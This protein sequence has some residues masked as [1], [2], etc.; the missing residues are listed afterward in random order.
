MDWM[1]AF[2][3]VRVITQFGIPVTAVGNNMLISREAY[4]STGGYEKIPFS[5]T[6]DFELFRQTLKQGWKYKNL[7]Q[8][9]VLALTVPLKTINHFFHQRKRWM[10]G[11]MQLPWYLVLILGLQGF[12][13]PFLILAGWLNPW[14]LVF[15]PLKVLMDFIFVRKGLEKVGE[16]GRAPHFFIHSL[17][18]P[19]MAIA[20]ILYSALPGKIN[21]K[22][23]KY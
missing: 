11:A 1:Y 6:E 10:T 16:A 17:G 13:L 20:Q 3:Q 14:F 4:F 22:G 18:A 7:L 2:S 21:W 19:F 8:A 12:M 15:W 5:I 23:R 9:E